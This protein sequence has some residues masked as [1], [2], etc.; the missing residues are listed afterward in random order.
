VSDLCF[1]K[2]T[3]NFKYA[4]KRIF[5]SYFEGEQA[6]YTPNKDAGF[7]VA[8]YDQTFNRALA[9]R[10]FIKD[11]HE[12]KASDGR[13]LV[14]LSGEGH[15]IEDE[16]GGGSILVNPHAKP[17]DIGDYRMIDHP[18]LRGWKWLMKTDDGKS[19]F[20]RGNMLV[21]PEI[22]DRLK[23]RLTTSWFQRNPVARALMAA[24]TSLKQTLFSVP[25]FH[26]VQETL[27]ALGHRIDPANLEEVDFSDPVTKGLAE[28]GLQLADY[29]ALAHFSEGVAGGGLVNKLPYVGPKL[30]A[31][32]EWLFQ[33][34]IP[35]LKLAVAKISLER[36]RET[37]PKWNEDQQLSAAASIA[38]DA[39]GE[40]PYR[41]WGSNPNMIDAFRAFLLAPDFAAS[42]ARFVARALRPGGR[43]QLT[44]IGVL[45]L[46]QYTTARAVNQALNGDAHW[47]PQNMFRIIY[48]N[49]AYSLRTIPSDLL[50]MFNEPRGFFSNRMSLASRAAFES[51]TGRDY[52]G[53]KRDFAE[54]VKDVLTSPIPM[55]VKPLAG[56]KWWEAA[57]S[58]FGVQDQRWDAVQ[59]LNERVQ[60]WKA[61]NAPKSP[62]DI[63][64]DA[65]N[66]RYAPLKRA[67][68]D[69]DQAAAK[70][71]YA[72]LVASTPPK[73]IP[74]K[75][76]DITESPEDQVQQ[77]FKLSYN[78]PFTGSKAYDE[79]FLQSLDATGKQEYQEASDLRQARFK[80][81]QSL[82]Q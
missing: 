82:R 53:V 74:R 61:K 41:Y 39:F 52:R 30:H 46:T 64:Y 24:Q 79:Q 14:E 23:N 45:A 43:E 21:H 36:N 17:E 26:Q 13:P 22:Y 76:G 66:D 6:G 54:Q 35:K 11:L 81:I 31:Y 58:A 18:A 47:E 5:D 25:G 55:S 75:S 49:H 65:D 44:A 70:K 48:K 12:G 80:M 37:Y 19:V 15:P 32:N 29:N 20:V 3:P 71:E 78:R 1:G 38:N 40:L 77:H 57:M 69:D 50:H 73:V 62:V 27:H 56:K 9:A 8:N 42:R 60:A 59:A 51:I 68:E 72:K 4:R 2:L 10:A 67:V 7:L 34:Y 33:D 28:H 16:H 63:V